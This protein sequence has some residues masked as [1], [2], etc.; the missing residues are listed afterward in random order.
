MF[1]NSKIF[2][3][4]PPIRLKKIFAILLLGVHSFNT[5]GYQLFFSFAENVADR[6]M[7]ASLDEN[8]YNESDLMEIRLPLNIPYTTNWKDYERCDGN[9]VLNGIHY[10]YVKRIVYNDTMRL[11]CIPNQQKTELFNTRNEYAKQATDLPAGKKSDQSTTKKNGLD[12]YKGG[13]FSH[14]FRTLVN[15]TT[16]SPFFNDTNLSTGFFMIPAQ[17]PDAIV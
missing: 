13:S 16:R 17:P 3:L 15:Y 11:Y 10:N 5:C 1:F 14:D 12:E 8:K 7:V 2:L 6:Q 4:C 9:I